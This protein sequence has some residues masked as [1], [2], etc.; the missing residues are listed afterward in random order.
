MLTTYLFSPIFL[1]LCAATATA[2]A[3]DVPFEVAKQR[4]AIS[5]QRYLVAYNSF[6]ANRLGPLYTH[7]AVQSVP[8]YPYVQGRKNIVEAFRSSFANVIKLEF[9]TT[10]VLRVAPRVYVTRGTYVTYMRAPAAD[11]GVAPDYGTFR[12]VYRFV[13]GTALI[14]LEESSAVPTLPAPLPRMSPVQRVVTAQLERFLITLFERDYA[15]LGRFYAADAEYANSAVGAPSVRG[16]E[17]IVRANREN[18]APVLLR[19]SRIVQLRRAGPGRFVHTVAVE[20]VVQRPNG[21]V[22][23]LPGRARATWRFAAGDAYPVITK[24]ES[25]LAQ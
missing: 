18:S 12:T 11:G 22:V 14:A 2:S 1:L 8:G 6:N 21:A 13:G 9:N 20:Y 16:R 17:N 5:D 7:N 23:V 3:N 15:N 19:R 25:M 10:S 24:M 4:I